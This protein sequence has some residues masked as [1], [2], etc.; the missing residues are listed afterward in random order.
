MIQAI[1]EIN[2][3]RG[4][5]IMPPADTE[6]IEN[7]LQLVLKKYNYVPPQQYIDFL[8]LSNGIVL[9]DRTVFGVDS[10]ITETAD[11]DDWGF[12]ANND[13]WYEALDKKYI[14][15]GDTDGYWWVQRKNDDTFLSLDSPTGDELHTYKDFDEMV[16]D[17]FDEYINKLRRLIE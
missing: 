8:R 12:I 4:R 17:I 3:K 11:N 6:T 5:K 7:F 14:V 2:Q 16:M 9:S 1:H 13:L 15:F 10:T